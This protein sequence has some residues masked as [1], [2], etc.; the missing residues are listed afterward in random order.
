MKE[1]NV[2]KMVADGLVEWGTEVLKE[3]SKH[4]DENWDADAV[5]TYMKR[6]AAYQAKEFLGLV[7]AAERLSNADAIADPCVPL[8]FPLFVTWD[9]CNYDIL[10]GN[11]DASVFDK[12]DIFKQIRAYA[13]E[14]N[15]VGEEVSVVIDFIDHIFDENERE[16]ELHRMKGG[17]CNIFNAVFY[18]YR[19]YESREHKFERDMLQDVLNEIAA[20]DN[21][22]PIFTS[23]DDE[24]GTCRVIYPNME[25]ACK[26][27]VALNYRPGSLFPAK[28]SAFTRGMNMYAKDD[29][30][31]LLEKMPRL[32]E[33]VRRESEEEN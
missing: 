7:S 10:M 17:L 26:A 31:I 13:T 25:E 8:M 23:S 2:F 18:T 20:R 16:K 28:M 33:A 3:A 22:D 19:E 14:H 15:I 12:E 24:K 29:N 4:P 5:T 1:M 6:H 27:I 30:D 9:N 11:V 32:R 21:D